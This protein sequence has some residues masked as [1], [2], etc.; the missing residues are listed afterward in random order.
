MNQSTYGNPQ[1]STSNLRHKTSRDNL[2]DE[3]LKVGDILFL[4]GAPVDWATSKDFVGF[5][6]EEFVHYVVVRKTL[7]DGFLEVNI[8]SF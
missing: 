1:G 5:S 6:L 7:E 8:V 3:E 4:Q 2:A